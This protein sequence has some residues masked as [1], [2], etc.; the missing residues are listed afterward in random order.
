MRFPE[1]GGTGAP[2]QIARM[3]GHGA[4]GGAG[5]GPYIRAPKADP[6]RFPTRSPD[7]RGNWR[8]PIVAAAWA[9][10]AADHVAVDVAV[11]ERVGRADNGLQINGVGA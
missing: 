5:S 11:D 1:R 6:P 2:P 8:R 10:A 7:R 4:G 3:G 9:R